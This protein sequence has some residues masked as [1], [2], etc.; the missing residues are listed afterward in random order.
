MQSVNLNP[1]PALQLREEFVFIAQRI[2]FTFACNDRRVERSRDILFDL[3]IY[4]SI[5]FTVT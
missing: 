1:G 5:W 2:L 4:C 3:K